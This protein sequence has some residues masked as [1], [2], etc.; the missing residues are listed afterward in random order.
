MLFNSIEF[1]IFIFV[2]IPTYYFS[3]KSRIPFLVL[4]CFFF[5]SYYKFEHIFI[6]ITIIVINYYA[7]LYI[8][9]LKEEYKRKR[10]LICT[11]ALS[12][13]FLILFKYTNFFVQSI[14]GVLHIFGYKNILF[15][16]IDILLPIGISFFTFQAIGYSVDV[17]QRKILPEKSFLTFASFISFFPQILAGPIERAKDLIPQIHNKPSFKYDNLVKG[18]SL[19]VWGLFQKIVIADRLSLF[20]TPIFENPLSFNNLEIILAVYLFSFQI[21]CDFSGYTDIAIGTARIM[22]IRLQKNFDSPYLSR[23]IIDFWRRWHITLSSWL[24]D[25]LYIPLGGNRKGIKLQFL[26]IMC[27]MSLGGLW[28]GNTWNF[29]IWGAFHGCLI[30][31]NY[32]IRILINNCQKYTKYFIPEDSRLFTVTYNII[33]ITITFHLVTL[34]WVLFRAK[35]IKDAAFIVY[36]LLFL[37]RDKVFTLSYFEGFDVFDLYLSIILCLII[38]IYQCFKSNTKAVSFFYSNTYFRWTVFYFMIIS[39]LFMSIDLNSEFIYFQF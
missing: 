8:S 2:A 39:I 6:L 34:G 38:T 16:P 26:A 21:Y 3:N 33:C 35:T 30:I 31:S 37:N 22:D 28:H 20:V 19:I 12:L 13:L 4:A 24:R 27:T 32:F 1:F 14:N 17:Y 23:N 10:I 18:S 36:T 29:V 25:Y 7:S 9:N 11:I 15:N 5:Y